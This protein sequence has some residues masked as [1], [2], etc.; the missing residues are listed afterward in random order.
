MKAVDFDCTE[1]AW[2]AGF[3]D[4]EGTT[5]LSQGRYLRAAVPQKGPT[6][7]PEVLVRFQRAVGVGQIYGPK[8]ALIYQWTTT[9]P[10]KSVQAI[11]AIWP[12]LSSVKRAQVMR[13][14]TDSQARAIERDAVASTVPSHEEELAWAAGLFAGDGCLAVEKRNLRLGTR[15]SL[16]MTVAQ[17]GQS[18]PEVL[19]KFQ[20]LM[21][22]GRIK[23]PREVEGREPKYGWYVC[24]RPVIARCMNLIWPWLGIDKREQYLHG[25]A[26]IVGLPPPHHLGRPGWRK[27]R[28]VRGHDYSQVYEWDGVRNGRPFHGRN[29][30]QCL[31]ERRA[32][33]R[34]AAL[35]R[36]S[37]PN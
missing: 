33:K 22:A 31:R 21:G 13:A 29:C 26:L 19:L 2:A 10:I 30:M 32:A 23:G 35:A 25:L 16:R 28:C 24:A 37:T 9:S 5:S 20:D 27:Q 18:R 1:L 4:A 11:A 34:A 7:V 14:A 15:Y 6:G 3:F 17:S 8:D 12:W 36:S